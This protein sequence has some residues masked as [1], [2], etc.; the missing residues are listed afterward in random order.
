ML[1]KEMANQILHTIKE[2]FMSWYSY[3]C[4]GFE[5]RRAFPSPSN[6]KK[7]QVYIC[8]RTKT[9]QFNQMK[10]NHKEIS[11]CNKNGNVKR[12]KSRFTQQTH[13]MHQRNASRHWYLIFVWF[14]IRTK[15]KKCAKQN[16][17][18]N[19][20]KKEKRIAKS[21]F[22]VDLVQS[23]LKHINGFMRLFYALLV[24]TQLTFI[25][26]FHANPLSIQL[27]AEKN[28]SW[29]LYFQ[30]NWN[31][32]RETDEC[33]KERESERTRIKCD[34]HSSIKHCLISLF[35]QDLRTV[36]S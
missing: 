24:H 35:K 11:M 14:T 30:A 23:K 2:K 6:G 25:S 7:S 28:I 5:L 29:N 15:W 19:Q 18:E 3:S 34:F 21:T 17:D 16:T 33:E 9:R 4:G 31:R 22:I 10:N 32:R 27:K 12:I 36:F 8:V 13:I 20:Q 26:Q 1:N